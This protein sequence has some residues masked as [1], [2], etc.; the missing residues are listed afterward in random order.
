M[1]FE[2]CRKPVEKIQ[3]SLIFNKNNQYF[4]WKPI[5]IFE[6]NSVNLLLRMIN[7]SEKLLY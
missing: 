7:N 6:Q 1:K 4:T 3:V 5:H 2:Y